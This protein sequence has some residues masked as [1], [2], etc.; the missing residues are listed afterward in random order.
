MVAA[1]FEG[2]TIGILGLAVSVLVGEEGALI[3]G[4]F[5]RLSVVLD[6]L[7]R[8]YSPS[9]VFLALVGFAIIVQL[10]KSLLLYLSTAM[11][12]YL[13]MDVRLGIQ[14]KVVSHMMRLSYPRISEY[15]PGSLASFIEQASCAQDVVDLTSN[16][17]RAVLMFIV[18]VGLML[19]VSIPMSVVGGIAVILMWFTLSNAIRKIKKLST[20]AASA[21]I[22]LWRWTVELLSA[23]RLLRIFNSTETAR[24]MIKKAREAEL[25]PERKA[26]IIDAAIKPSLE[27]F[28]VFGAGV[29][30]IAGYALAGDGAAAAIPSLFV[31]VVVF[32]R[33]K[34]QL[35]ALNDFR[36][37]LAKLLPRL[38][39]LGKFL[40]VDGESYEK[41]H[42]KKFEGLKK[43]I[44]FK[45]VGFRYSDSATQVLTSISFSL[46]KG[47]TI[48][49]VG[50]SGAGKSTITDLMA[51]LYQ[52]TYGSIK[53]DGCDL[54]SL[55]IASWRAQLGVV[56]QSVLLLNA[57]VKEN[58]C[59]GREQDSLETVKAA[60]RAAHADQ[61][62]ENLE[63][64]YDTILGDKGFRLSGGQKQRI[65]LA[66]ALYGS[67]E[68]LIL[69]EATSALDTVSEKIIQLAFTEMKKSRTILVV[70]HR[71]STIADADEILVVEEGK[72]VERGTRDEL[73]SQQGTFS[74]LWKLQR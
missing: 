69:D 51:G 18:Y 66:R 5:G 50:A 23:P 10:F 74:H 38:S 55:N 34:P 17:T 68:L 25:I 16:T 44:E 29:F 7:L 61:F 42:G 54:S 33:L 71:L 35:Q 67:P 20:E 15:P 27:F 21:K 49:L 60:A 52:P 22:F 24:E 72:I 59:F 57:S 40:R 39:I 26:T 19:W 70:A 4:T 43:V 64:G 47:A 53:V 31:F 14:E 62:I 36:A 8:R 1:V 37:K 46:P 28:A 11:Q 3:A 73:L 2:G 32:Y 58:I 30:L 63:L 6:A 12:I 56:E 48:A 9:G 65:A 45:D 41:M 13:A